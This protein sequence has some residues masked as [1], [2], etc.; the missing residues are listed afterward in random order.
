MIQWV[1]VLDDKRRQSP[2][3]MGVLGCIPAKADPAFIWEVITGSTGRE[4]EN[5]TGN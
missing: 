3:N 5:E 1:S 2:G 4:R